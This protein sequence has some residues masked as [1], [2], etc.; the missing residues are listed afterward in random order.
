MILLQLKL[1]NQ[2]INGFEE[3][4]H[5]NVAVLCLSITTVVQPEKQELHQKHNKKCDEF[6]FR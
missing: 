2:I 4:L 5:S 6:I 1:F 3:S